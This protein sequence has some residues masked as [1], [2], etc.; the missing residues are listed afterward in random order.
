[1]WLIAKKIA[2]AVKQTKPLA[3]GG[4]RLQGYRPGSA[5]H[6]CGTRRRDD[7]QY[8]GWEGSGSW[9]TQFR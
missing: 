5:P 4:I 1:V 6:Q 8:D 9:C 3:E 7:A 2:H